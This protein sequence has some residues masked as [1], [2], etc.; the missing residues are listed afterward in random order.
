MGKP[1]A[2]LLTAALCGLACLAVL[3]LTDRALIEGGVPPGR[4]RRAAL[5]VRDNVTPFQKWG[6]RTFTWGYLERSYDAAWYFTQTD[7]DDCRRPFQA[8]LARALER[9]A[10]VDLYLL[11]HSNVFIRW[12]AV[13]P[14]EGRRRLRLVYNTGCG[15]LDQGPLWLH[16]GAKAYVGHPGASAS[17]IFYTYFL[18]RWARGWTL[19]EAIDES[20]RRMHTTL[21]RTAA[22][23][24][25]TLDAEAVQQDSAAFCHGDEGLRLGEAP[26]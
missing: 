11:A 21:R 13:F 6:S 5:A 16:L 14:A 1:T 26:P 17:P 10:A 25:G 15:D 20:N 12:V 4:E 7:A 9:Y 19:R 8:A 18:R 24:F 23:A 3:T 22:L 2:A